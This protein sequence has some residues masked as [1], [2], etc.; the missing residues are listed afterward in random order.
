MSINDYLIDYVFCM[1]M[2]QV[3]K[4]F[5]VFRYGPQSAFVS[6][7]GSTMMDIDEFFR[8]WELKKKRDNTK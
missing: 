5:K 7:Y 2:R 6:G 4:E 8:L 3:P 1:K